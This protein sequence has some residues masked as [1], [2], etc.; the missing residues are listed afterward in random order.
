MRVDSS[1]DWR[2]YPPMLRC[3]DVAPLYGYTLLTTRKLAQ[4][5]SSKVPTPCGN[6]PLRFRRDDVRRH[7]ERLAVTR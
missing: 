3:D 7:Y 2:D 1:I 5:R 6:R 4:R